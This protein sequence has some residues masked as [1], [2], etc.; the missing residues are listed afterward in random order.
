MHNVSVFAL[1]WLQ[2]ETLISQKK[3]LH[4]LFK[5]SSQKTN[6]C[7]SEGF[8]FVLYF[9]FVKKCVFIYVKE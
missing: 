5:Y 7:K 9:F 6:I 3:Y 2:S 1:D 4:I 8:F